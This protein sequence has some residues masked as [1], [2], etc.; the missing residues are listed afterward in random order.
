MALV[1]LNLSGHANSTLDELGYVFPG[2]I[3]VDLSDKDLPQK[4]VCLLSN[5]MTSGDVVT[6]VLPGLAPLAA[7]TLTAIHGITGSFPSLVAL[8]RKEDRFEPGEALNLQ[9]FR[10]NVARSK[11]RA[12]VIEL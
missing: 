3:Q 4:I 12:N 10:N 5:Y 6:C 11:G 8:I 1:K 7:I 9:D 2:T